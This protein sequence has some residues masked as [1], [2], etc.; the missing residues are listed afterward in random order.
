MAKDS[1]SLH[2]E[3]RLHNLKFS[4]GLYLNGKAHTT[5]YIILVYH[6]VECICW[7][8]DRSEWSE[9]PVIT[10]TDNKIWF[11]INMEKRLLTKRISKKH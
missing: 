1:L 11:P 6:R 8:E 3:P 10:D 9:G 5:D 2:V 4:P 7:V